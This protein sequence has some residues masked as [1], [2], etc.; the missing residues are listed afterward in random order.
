MSTKSGFVAIAVNVA[1]VI[2]LVLSM[3]SAAQAC[4]CIAQ[5]DAATRFRAADRLVVARVTRLQSPIEWLDQ[6]RVWADIQ[7]L[8]T[9]K[10][11]PRPS[12]TRVWTEPQTSACGL[13]M[14]VGEVYLLDVDEREEAQV[15]HCTSW[16]IGAG[17]K[18]GQM[19]RQMLDI[20]DRRQHAATDRAEKGPSA[21]APDH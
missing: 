20:R 17:G 11:S 12:P 16:A 10:T 9:L 21:S 19:L 3:G 4:S 13:P 5:N 2:G 14:L 8:D 18:R 15:N 6:E 1:L 7:I